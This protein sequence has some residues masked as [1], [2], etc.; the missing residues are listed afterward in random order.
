MYSSVSIYVKNMY[1][2]PTI[3]EIFI[4][5]FLEIFSQVIPIVYHKLVVH[6]KNTIG[7]EP[8]V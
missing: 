8:K 1:K 4:R 5:R 6:F 3:D 2:V 7:I